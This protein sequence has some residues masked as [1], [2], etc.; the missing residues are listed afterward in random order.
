MRIAHVSPVRPKPDKSTA[1]LLSRIGRGRDIGSAQRAPTRGSHTSGTSPDASSSSTL[2]KER[3]SAKER[4]AKDQPHHQLPHRQVACGRSGLRHERDSGGEQEPA[5]G[6]EQPEPQPPVARAAADRAIFGHHAH[7]TKI[8][9]GQELGYSVP[10][11]TS[12]AFVLP[13]R[14]IDVGAYSAGPPGLLRDVLRRY[15]PLHRRDVSAQAVAIACDR[16]GAAWLLHSDAARGDPLVAAGSVDVA[17]SQKPGCLG[18]IRRN[19][20]PQ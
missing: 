8:H 4:K 10:P 5:E 20:A 14:Q 15:G 12:C 13:V 6:E 16:R 1:E 17:S 19:L 7:Q 9:R 3:R 18:T 2:K 11:L